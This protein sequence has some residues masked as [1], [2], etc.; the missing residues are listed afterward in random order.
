MCNMFANYILNEFFLVLREWELKSMYGI[1]LSTKLMFVLIKYNFN[2]LN[3]L[4]KHMIIYKTIEIYGIHIFNK[5]ILVFF[6]IK[7]S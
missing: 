5:Y 6:F 3:S 4:F 2:F 7:S 1:N